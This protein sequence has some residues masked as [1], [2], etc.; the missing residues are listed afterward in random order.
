MTPTEYHDKYGR[1]MP[2]PR[3]R[4]LAATIRVRADEAR[5]KITPDWI[6]KLASGKVEAKSTTSGRASGAKKSR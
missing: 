6:V 4:E 5:G 1:D 3:E 2:S